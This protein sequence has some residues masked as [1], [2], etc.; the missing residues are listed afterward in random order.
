MSETSPRKIIIDCDPGVDDALAIALAIESPD[1]ELIGLTT[2]YGNA[3]IETT[4]ANA[5]RVIE[6]S[7]QS[8]PVA[9]G[10][11][12]PSVIP[13]PEPPDFVHGKDGFG[14]TYFPAPVSQ[15]IEQPAAEFIVDAI[16]A[17]PGEVSLV[18]VAGLTNIADALA[19]DPSIVEKV[20]EVVLMGGALYRPG[21]VTPVA[22]ANIAEDPHAADIVFTASWKLT[23][24]GLDATLSTYLSRARLD[25]I[26]RSNARFGDFLYQVH[27]FYIDF[28]ASREPDLDGCAVH[29]SAALLYLLDP[30]LF[31]TTAGPIRVV[32]EGI[33]IGQTIMA[34]YDYQ[35]ELEPWRGK[36][37]VTVTLKVDSD[38]LIGLIEK[39]LS[40]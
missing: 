22:E 31:E 37:D 25:G 40:D 38:R 30:T 26:R 34:A 33:A 3:D 9:R 29:D 17:N 10:A 35:R 32:V 39:I 12:R 28:Y 15:P 19:L 36:P 23:M 5:L 13:L 16:N 24:V 18:C 6:M 1:F 27:Q 8:I 14:N 21:N 20:Q 11:G 7:G 2:L 4:T